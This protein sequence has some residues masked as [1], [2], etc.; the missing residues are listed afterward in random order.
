TREHLHICSLL[1]IKK[2]LVALTKVD[3]VAKEW[4]DLVKDDVREFLKGTFLEASPILP[5]S[6]ITGAGLEEL[7]DALGRVA[8]DIEGQ[9]GAGIFRLPVDRAF[10]I[11][12]FGTV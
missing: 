9:S 2:G 3:M 5:V 6:S 10:T 7:L 4:L 1:G 12:G 11:K 8:S